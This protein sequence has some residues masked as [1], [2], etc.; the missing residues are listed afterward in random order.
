MIGKQKQSRRFKFNK[1]GIE[2]LKSE[3]QA[4]AR[5]AEFTD[6]GCCGLKILVNKAV[7]PRKT[8]F[9]RTTFN[10]RK[11]AIRLGEWPGMSVEEARQ[12]A[13]EYKNMISRGQDPMVERE[14]QKAVLT[15]QQFAEQHYLTH[16]RQNK[17]SWLWDERML[18]NEL[19]QVFGR[20]T[21]SAISKRDCQK[22]LDS[23]AMRASGPTANRH[24]SLLMRMFNLAIQ[25]DFMEGD[26]P[27][28]GIH[29]H[30][31]N[32]AREVFLSEEEIHLLIQALSQMT[33]R[34]SACAVL[35]L[36][37]SGKR[38]T[39]A[40]SITYDDLDMDN[41]IAYL[42]QDT[43]KGGKPERVFLNDL[44]MSALEEVA[45]YRQAGNP[46]VF[47][48]SGKS[49]RLLSPKRTFNLA[50]K[51]AGIDRAVRLHDL[52]H[53]FASHLISNGASLYEV[54]K[55]L[56]HKD[57]TMTQRYAHLAEDTLRNLSDGVGERFSQTNG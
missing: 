23:V 18:R 56:G 53:T 21:L 38:L 3:P 33:E 9:L 19:F 20:Y 46:H 8:F 40:M 45:G 31:E 11:I 14:R 55:L 16:A 6:E 48:G 35:F 10:R 22:Y 43:T 54:Q 1:R 36:I 39:E 44:A 26:N 52:R 12:L 4:R 17:K 5:E 29:K 32:P 27:L 42:R 2:A 47:P 49:G 50:K 34:I 15:F 24:R 7:H 25:W 37:S 28:S 13:N 57:A 41:R 51:M 30:K